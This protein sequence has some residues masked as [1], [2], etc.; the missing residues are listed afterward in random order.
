ILRSNASIEPGDIDTLVTKLLDRRPDPL[1]TTGVLYRMAGV[2]GVAPLEVKTRAGSNYFVKVVDW[3]TK[4]TVLT[5]F[6]RGG[7]HFETL[8][9]LGSYEIRYASGQA[10][11]GDVIDFGETST[12]ARC[13]EKFDFT[14]SL[15]GYSGF[16]V[17]LILQ[18]RG[19]LETVPI[20]PSDF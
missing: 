5:A 19:N 3:T 12:Y 6:I 1:P 10:W 16:I 2:V 13:D 15:Q 4:A 7:E 14:K 17:E 8:L 11:Y 20:S 9:P 18:Q